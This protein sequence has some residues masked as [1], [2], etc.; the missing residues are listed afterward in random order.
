MGSLLCYCV[1]VR[2]AVG[3]FRV[4]DPIFRT[5]SQNISPRAYPKAQQHRQEFAFVHTLRGF[6]WVRLLTMI[7]TTVAWNDLVLV[8]MLLLF[9]RMLHLHTELNVVVVLRRVGW[10]SLHFCCDAYKRLLLHRSRM[11]TCALQNCAA[12]SSRSSIAYP[13][14]L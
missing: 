10:S 5:A 13:L 8:P 1:Q 3:S 12:H 2:L 4:C 6:W 11:C 14:L 9:D 7:S